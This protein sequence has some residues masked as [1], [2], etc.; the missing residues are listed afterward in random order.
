M[1]AK[2]R[3]DLRS[4]RFDQLEVEENAGQARDERKRREDNLRTGAELAR[5]T[6]LLENR[7]ERFTDY[8]SC[9]YLG[10]PL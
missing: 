6:Q 1:V 5:G 7:I 4:K 9:S 2:V 3:E 8:F 10:I